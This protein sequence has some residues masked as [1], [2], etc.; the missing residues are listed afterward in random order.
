M[1]QKNVEVSAHKTNEPLTND[2]GTT[3]ERKFAAHIASDMIQTVINGTN[4]IVR[5]AR[6]LLIVFS[7]ASTAVTGN[8]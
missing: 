4:H 2:S 6:R 7:T 5:G 3:N 1:L 8:T